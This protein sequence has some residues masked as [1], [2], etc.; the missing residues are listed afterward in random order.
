[1]LTLTQTNCKSGIKPKPEIQNC[2][3]E[4]KSIQTRKSKNTNQ[5][6]KKCKPENQKTQTRNQINPN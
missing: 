3:P 5:K 4:I 1:M 6:I 2:K